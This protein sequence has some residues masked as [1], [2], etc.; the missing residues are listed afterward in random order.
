[1]G[2][3][4]YE[5]ILAA[6]IDLFYRKGYAETSLQDIAAASGLTKA[7][8]YHYIN[9]KEDLLF[10][11]VEMV[12][13]RM[14]TWRERTD[15]A[16]IPDLQI[17]TIIA[18]HIVGTTS[19]APEVRMFYT[20]YQHLTSPRFEPILNERKL[21]AHAVRDVIAR[22]REQ[23]MFAQDLDVRIVG[24]SFLAMLNSMYSWF[25]SNREWKAHD[26]WDTYSTLILRGLGVPKRR[27]LKLVADVER[28]GYFTDAD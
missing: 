18:S 14:G 22:G 15:P 17:A 1:M 25:D 9:S 26:L 24:V 2:A 4:R 19:Q 21:Y 28:L 6:A 12:H 27:A 16:G 3:T 10:S 23:G 5:E 20:E 13:F 11:I 7:S 8:L